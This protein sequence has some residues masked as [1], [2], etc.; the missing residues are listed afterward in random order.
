MVVIQPRLCGS[1]L[2]TYVSFTEFLK[3]RKIPLTKQRYL[4][5]AETSDEA[6]D[7]TKPSRE[8]VDPKAM[9]LLEQMR[10]IVVKDRALNDKVSAC[11]SERTV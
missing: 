10:D 11:S 4:L 2:L 3:L 5:D 1:G 7:E 8:T 6:N 9:D